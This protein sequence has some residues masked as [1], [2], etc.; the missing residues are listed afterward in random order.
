V[1]AYGYSA[2]LLRELVGGEVPERV[3]VG[4]CGLRS[5]TIEW[6]RVEYWCREMLERE[7]THYFQ[8]QALTAMLLT[9]QNCLRLEPPDYVVLPNL[10][11]GRKPKAALHHYVASSKRS[12]FQYGWRKVMADAEAMR[13][14]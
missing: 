8:E 13:R 4:I 7:G 3:N 12:Y 1:T 10:A 6:D 9:G 2:Q 14:S 11:E 5:D